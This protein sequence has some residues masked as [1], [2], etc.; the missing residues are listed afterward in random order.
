MKK[1]TALF[2]IICVSMMF[3]INTYAVVSPNA[4]GIGKSVNVVTTSHANPTTPIYGSQILSTNY[5]NNIMQLESYDIDT[6]TEN[7]Q[8]GSSLN[9]YYA[10]NSYTYQQ[11]TGLS[12]TY[13]L[14]SGSL[15]SNFTESLASGAYRN[16]GQFYYSYI[17]E[18][19]EKGV[20]I[21]NYLSNKSQFTN[22]LSI[23]LLL[24]LEQLNYGNMSYPD[25][26]EI[27]G[28]HLIAQGI[29]GGRID[30]NYALTTDETI[31]NTTQ[32]GEITSDI[33]AGITY[34][35]NQAQLSTSFQVS[36]VSSLSSYNVNL[37][38][39]MIAV[40]GQGFSTT[41]QGNVSQQYANW[42]SSIDSNPVL[43][44]YGYRGLIPLWDIVPT[45]YQN[46]KQ[47][48]YNEFVTYA[49]DYNLV[50]GSHSGIVTDELQIRSTTYK[51]TDAGRFVH[52]MRDIIS[53]TRWNSLYNE[54][55]LYTQGI[56][57][58]RIKFSLIAKEVYDGYQ[59]IFLY[60]NDGTEST[61]GNPLGT[62]MFEHGPGKYLGDSITYHFE[63]DV[64]LSS[65][66]NDF[67]LRYGASGSG[68]DTWKNWD[69]RVTLVFY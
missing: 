15:T 54:A 5:L 16:T 64:P 56:Q 44:G 49:N 57:R 1:L 68:L 43:I 40:G 4:P 24:A 60:N 3:T 50:Q 25:F 62:I 69:L 2:I 27:Y 9:S 53:L 30:I 23:D 45:T 21:N 48:M 59:Y 61:S 52:N 7:V 10:N 14:F 46:V 58:V 8:K 20:Y 55:Y 19:Q 34:T 13:K 11:E 26:F 32:T 51:I 18:R 28:T 47:N 36:S 65:I 39:K 38:Y 37:S 33:Y 42:F 17:L 41:N 67:V 63:F 29:Y 31:F 22:N 35:P 66:G 12:G 6:T